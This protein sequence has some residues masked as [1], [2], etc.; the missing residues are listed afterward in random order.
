MVPGYGIQLSRPDGTAS[1]APQRPRSTF[2]P[3]AIFWPH[4]NLPDADYNG[5][6]LSYSRRRAGPVRGQIVCDWVCYYFAAGKLAFIIRLQKPKEETLSTGKIIYVVATL[7]S[8]LTSISI[9][10]QGNRE[11]AVFVGLWAPTILNLGQSLVDEE[12]R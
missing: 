10:R 6:I 2:A 5:R 11:L 8:I 4:G 1:L 3:N 7:A 12:Q 9:Y